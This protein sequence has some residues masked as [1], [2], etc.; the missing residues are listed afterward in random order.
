MPLK[1]KTELQD[2]SELGSK[3]GIEDELRYAAGDKIL[4]QEKKIPKEETKLEETNNSDSAESDLN[5]FMLG[6]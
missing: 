4:G 6:G 5:Y 3:Q 2:Q 1:E